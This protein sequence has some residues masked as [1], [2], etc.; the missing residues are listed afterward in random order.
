M[1]EPTTQQTLSPTRRPSWDEYFLAIAEEV[2]RRSPDPNTKHGCVLVDEGNRV[3]ST[4]Y[5]GPV[6][7]LSHDLIRLDRPDKQQQHF[8]IHSIHQQQHLLLH[9]LLD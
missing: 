6:S 7:G 8:C 1:P 9:K 5:N 4:G 3:L 2:S